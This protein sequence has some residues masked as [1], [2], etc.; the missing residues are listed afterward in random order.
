M[1]G[2]TASKELDP[3]RYLRWVRAGIAA[4]AIDLPGHGERADARLQQAVQTIEVIARAIDELDTVVD[5]LADPRWNGAFDTSRIAIG[6]MSAG[7]M[8]ALARLCRP[9]RFVAAAVEGTA[10]NYDF[11]RARGLWNSPLAD[12][13]EPIRHVNQWRPIPLLAL[14]SEADQWVPVSAIRTFT[15]ALCPLYE[16]GGASPDLV[17]L[18]T[19]PSTGAPNEH[20]GFGRVSNDAKNLQTQWLARVLADGPPGSANRP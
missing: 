7:G 20:Y 5:A 16:A 18:H 12:S 11:M 1:H 10:G 4:C 9:H 17:E 15:E 8:V 3:G 2:R 19:W 6:G 14:H 13:L